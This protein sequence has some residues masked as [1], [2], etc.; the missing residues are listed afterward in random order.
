MESLYNETISRLEVS[1]ELYSLFKKMGGNSTKESGTE[2]VADL[3]QLTDYDLLPL[4][5]DMEAQVVQ[6][7]YA[8]LVQTPPA[9]RDLNIR[10]FEYGC[11]QVR[12]PSALKRPGVIILPGH[13]RPNT[14]NVESLSLPSIYLTQA[15]LWRGQYILCTR[16]ERGKDVNRKLGR[17]QYQGGTS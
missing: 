8:I 12:S 7:V 17:P 5:A 13:C 2:P 11:S 10:A 4:S 3:S 1:N 6:Q 16:Y 9:D 15:Q 14:L